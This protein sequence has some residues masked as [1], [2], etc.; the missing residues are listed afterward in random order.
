M[1]E[2]I[3]SPTIPFEEAAVEESV[4]ESLISFSRS[5]KTMSVSFDT[6]VNGSI[7]RFTL[8]RFVDEDTKRNNIFLHHTSRGYFEVIDISPYGNLKHPTHVGIK[9]SGLLA[10]TIHP[11]EDLERFRLNA[12][13]QHIMV[14]IIC[15]QNQVNDE[16][17]D[18]VELIF[19]YLKMLEA[20]YK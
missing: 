12:L 7:E 13:I 2:G 14:E 20:N 6:I 1:S 3:I 17:K 9:T 16:D 15:L 10:L 11:V 8:Y 5:N 18:T 4:F 19:E